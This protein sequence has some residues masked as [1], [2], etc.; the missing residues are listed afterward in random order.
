MPGLPKM[1]VMPSR[2]ARHCP[3][4]LRLPFGIRR[5]QGSR[6]AHAISRHLATRYQSGRDRR[7]VA[8]G[9]EDESLGIH[10]AT[11][12]EDTAS[13]AGITIYSAR[14][15]TTGSIRAARQDRKSTRL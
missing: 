2:L 12:R 4:G 7:D 3:H 15:A 14:N 1:P 13:A 9:W 5:S 6:A 10:L 8:F 11:L